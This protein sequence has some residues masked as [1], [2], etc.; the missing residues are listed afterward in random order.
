MKEARA[1]DQ[2]EDGRGE[3]AARKGREASE[4]ERRGTASNVLG[5]PHD[6]PQHLHLLVVWRLVVALLLQ[7]DLLDKPLGLEAG[8]KRVG[9]EGG[10]L[11][12]VGPDLQL[13]V[14]LR[15]V[16]PV[17]PHHPQL[18]PR[19]SPLRRDAA[20]L[21]VAI[22]PQLAILEG[23]ATFDVL[24]GHAERTPLHAGVQTRNP[25]RPPLTVDPHRLR[26]VYLRAE[27]QQHVEVQERALSPEALPALEEPPEAAAPAAH[28][29]ATGVGV[30]ELPVVAAEQVDPVRGHHDVGVGV[31]RLVDPAELLEGPVEQGLLVAAGQVNVWHHAID[32]VGLLVGDP[33]NVVH[34]LLHVVLDVL[35]ADLHRDACILDRLLRQELGLARLGELADSLVHVHDVPAA[36]REPQ[37]TK[38]AWLHEHGPW[39][40][41]GPGCPLVERWRRGHQAPVRDLVVVAEHVQA[42]LGHKLQEPPHLRLISD[43]EHA[44]VCEDDHMPRGAEEPRQQQNE[45]NDKEAK[46]PYRS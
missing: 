23:Q 16:V 35:P 18:R 25:A 15:W 37:Q 13:Q 30:E 10:V 46:R 4:G 11:Q 45:S 3:V 38:D 20:R 21:F 7:L 36:S 1:A 33:P 26:D 32:V 44:A 14:P 9:H 40:P 5:N 2:E 34:H 22:D 8:R 27:R 31:V 28:E 19:A 29:K 41:G 39:R 12:H 6:F 43:V 42:Q 24:A 17:A